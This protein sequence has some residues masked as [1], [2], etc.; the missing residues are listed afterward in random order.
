MFDMLSLTIE[1]IVSLTDNFMRIGYVT[2][3]N[4]HCSYW[5]MTFSASCWGACSHY[6]V[7]NLFFLRWNSTSWDEFSRKWNKPVHAFLLR[8]VYASSIS[9]YKLSRT[10][11]MF[12]TFL[13]SALA[14][15]LVMAVVTQ[16][17]RWGF[18]SPRLFLMLIN[19][20]LIGC[21]YFYYRSVLGL[22]F[23]QGSIMNGLTWPHHV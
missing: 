7:P 11:A 23:T 4:M 18:T 22:L 15:E 5:L 2:P 12:V 6:T 9:S 16:K 20:L 3:S 21:T 19:M 17:F 13:I 14:H 10:S 1:R 8:H